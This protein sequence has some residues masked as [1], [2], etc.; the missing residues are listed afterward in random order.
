MK[1]KSLKVP[2]LTVTAAIALTA[3]GG[4][5]KSAGGIE[6]KKMADALH[7]VMEAD[8]TVYT[9]YIIK[10]LANDGKV[11][12]ASEHWKDEKFNQ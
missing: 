11:I 12:K 6:P 3:C 5:E 4:E 10:R 8:R 9:K 2:M 1:M 7:A